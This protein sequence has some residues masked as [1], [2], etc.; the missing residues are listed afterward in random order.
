LKDIVDTSTGFTVEYYIRTAESSA[1]VRDTV[2]LG[3]DEFKVMIS[4][5]LEGVYG[6]STGGWSW[7][8]LYINE[9]PNIITS[10]WHSA[11]HHMA[12]TVT[13]AG[14]SGDNYDKVQLYIDGRRISDF[15]TWRHAYPHSEPYTI[16]MY[17]FMNDSNHRNKL[18]YYDIAQL[19]VWDYPKYDNVDT[20]QVPAKFYVD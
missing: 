1:W 9:S 15:T 10:P 8:T 3:P 20:Y 4:N 6:Y 14:S 13:H 18:G 11:W 5:S 17:N 7:G 19:A 16:W 2:G 12:Y